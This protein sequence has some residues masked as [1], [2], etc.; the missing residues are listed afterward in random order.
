MTM[1][2]EDTGT[3]PILFQ[4]RLLVEGAVLNVDKNLTLT[5]GSDVQGYMRVETNRER[6]T[7]SSTP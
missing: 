7:M 5:N 2:S 1:K 4:L 3:T 6:H